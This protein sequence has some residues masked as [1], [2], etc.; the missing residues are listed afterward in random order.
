MRRSVWVLA[1]L[2]LGLARAGVALGKDVAE[3]EHERLSDEMDRLA[4]RNVWAGVERKYR[5]LERLGVELT[6]EDYLHGATAAR[7]LGDMLSCYRRLKEAARLGGSKEVVDWLWDIDNNYGQVELISVPARSAELS[8]KEMPFDPNQR[9]AVEAA[10]KSAKEDGIF[11]GMLPK[12][13]YVFAGQPFKIEPG[14]SVRIEVSPK[15]RRQGIIDPVIVYRELPDAVV[16]GEK[17]A[18]D[19]GA[20]DEEPPPKEEP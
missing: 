7:E 18:E 13:E 5:E 2:L 1:W 6:E 16:T 10:I 15:A 8:A 4:E 3:A 14:V 12:G 9:K 11:V 19:A 17:K 20:D